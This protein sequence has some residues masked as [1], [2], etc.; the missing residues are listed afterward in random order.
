[1]LGTTEKLRQYATT[2]ERAYSSLIY[3][4]IGDTF[5]PCIDNIDK[6][7]WWRYRAT[8]VLYHQSSV[9]RITSPQQDINDFLGLIPEIFPEPIIGDVEENG[10]AVKDKNGNTV[11]TRIVKDIDRQLCNYLR[12]QLAILDD[13]DTQVSMFYGLSKEQKRAIQ[14]ELDRPLEDFYK[15]RQK[16]KGN[17]RKK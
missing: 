7:L 9:I 6:I 15:E 1:M 4:Y 16:E 17:E 10:V 8:A 11:P 14:N 3:S 12:N 2:L 13:D 5:S